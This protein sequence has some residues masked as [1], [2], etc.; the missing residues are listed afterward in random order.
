MS[1]EEIVDGRTDAGLRTNND[2]N[3]SPG[4]L[5]KKERNPRRK[6][7]LYQNGKFG[8][9]RKDRYFSG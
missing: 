8:A 7:L 2:H 9:M 5:K 4:E 6:V 3:S 1:L